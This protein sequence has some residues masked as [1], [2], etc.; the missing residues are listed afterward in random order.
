[1][2]ERAIELA[3]DAANRGLL[4]EV[5]W[6]GLTTMLPKDVSAIQ[7]NEMRFA[8]FA[9][10]QHVF[11]SIMTLLEEGTEATAADMKRIGMISAELQAFEKYLHERAA[12]VPV[13]TD[14][15]KAN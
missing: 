1:M 13:D 12:K 2:S 6:L 3:R 4:I 7:Y 10:A 11:S 14:K 9:G 5:G 15:G 8:F